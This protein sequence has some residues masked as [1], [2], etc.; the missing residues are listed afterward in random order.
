MGL[1]WM[2]KM[3]GKKKK[4]AVEEVVDENYNHRR[5]TPIKGRSF[6]TYQ[7]KIDKIRKQYEK[8]F[9]NSEKQKETDN[10]TLPKNK[11][12]Y[13]CENYPTAD[14][15]MKNYKVKTSNAKK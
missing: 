11:K 1:N 13:F 2:T 14:S 10:G 8:Q 7:N 3:Y 4:P 5:R 12:G 15:Y 9:A 6:L